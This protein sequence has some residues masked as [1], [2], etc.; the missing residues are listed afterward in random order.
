MSP[1]FLRKAIKRKPFRPFVIHLA[2]G[3]SIPV[4]SPEFV[5]MPK[6]GRMVVVQG[7]NDSAHIIDLLLVTDLEFPH[8]SILE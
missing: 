4:R 6:E 2:G 8:T 3:R 5:E 7:V 1:E